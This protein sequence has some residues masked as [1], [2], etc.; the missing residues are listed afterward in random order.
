MR[1]PYHIE[2]LATCNILLRNEKSRKGL[3][4]RILAIAV[5]GMVLGAS[6]AM[7]KDLTGHDWRTFNQY[8]KILYLI[9]FSKGWETSELNSGRSPKLENSSA[10]IADRINEVDA[11]FDAFPLCHSKPLGIMASMLRL[12]WEGSKDFT[13]QSIGSSCG[14]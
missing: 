3:M 9:G 6:P 2:V 10:T 11:F 13:L 4:R 12:T 1:E 8:Y 7:A 14:R 5:F